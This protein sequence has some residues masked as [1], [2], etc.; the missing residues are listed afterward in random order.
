MKTY[1]NISEKWGDTVEV[2]VDDYRQQAVAFGEN[3]NE[4]DIEETNDGVFIDGRQVG[5]PAVAITVA[6][7]WT[8]EVFDLG[9]AHIIQV[10]KNLDDYPWPMEDAEF[11]L[12]VDDANN[13]Q[14]WLK[15]AADYL[16]AKRSGDI[17][18]GS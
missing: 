2:T 17:I 15:K 7:P 9:A 8:G 11:T 4:L 16:G 14:E 12:A 18:L 1:I 10:S 3:P 13:R 5:V 6:N